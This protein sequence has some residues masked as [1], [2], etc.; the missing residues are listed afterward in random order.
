MFALTK[1]WVVHEELKLVQGWG[2]SR[3]AGE[4]EKQPVLCGAAIRYVKWGIWILLMLL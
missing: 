3:W 1:A 4:L 2:S